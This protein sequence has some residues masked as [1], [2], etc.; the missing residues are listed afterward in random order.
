MMPERPYWDF[1]CKIELQNPTSVKVISLA[2]IVGSVANR[3]VQKS[4]R[5]SVS[6]S[7]S[8]RHLRR[9]KPGHSEGGLTM[10]DL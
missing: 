5:S 7:A 1:D 9:H 2:F 6:L 4:R 10:E 8:C 3:H